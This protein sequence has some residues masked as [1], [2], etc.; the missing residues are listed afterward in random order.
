ME[1]GK[2]AL[3]IAEEHRKL[4][5]TCKPVSNVYWIDARYT[6]GSYSTNYMTKVDVETD[7]I[8]CEAFYHLSRTLA[9]P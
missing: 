7:F 1:N 8:W 4:W 9:I 2:R 3:P 5:P 6:N